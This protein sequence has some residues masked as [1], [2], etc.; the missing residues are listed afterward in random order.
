[1]PQACLSS[2][3]W[4]RDAQAPDTKRK[5]ILSGDTALNHN[6]GLL[7]F[8]VWHKMATV[9]VIYKIYS[10]KCNMAMEQKAGKQNSVL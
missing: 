7:F 6:S 2:L 9:V 3:P 10:V 1:M 5:E 8:S 4:S